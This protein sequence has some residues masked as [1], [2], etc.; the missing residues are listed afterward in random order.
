MARKTRQR[1]RHK[2]SQSLQCGYCEICHIDYPDLPTHLQSAIHQNYVSQKSNFIS[3]DKLINSEANVDSFL[4]QNSKRCLRSRDLGSLKNSYDESSNQSEITPI[5][6]TESNCEMTTK[7]IDHNK[8]CLR[9]FFKPHDSHA[10]P[11][12]NDS[13]DTNDLNMSPSYSEA[14]SD[15]TVEKLS[16]NKRCLRSQ[17][18]N[19]VKNSSEATFNQGESYYKSFRKN[20]D[21]STPEANSSRLRS[22]IN[23]TLDATIENT[24]NPSGLK[25][26]QEAKNLKIGSNSQDHCPRR[27]NM[28]QNISASPSYKIVG[29]KSKVKEQESRSDKKSTGLV[30]KFKRI[31]QSELL[32]L[33]DEAENFMFPKRDDTS[34]SESED[35]EKING[36]DK[37]GRMDNGGMDMVCDNSDSDTNEDNIKLSEIRNKQRFPLNPTQPDNSVGDRVGLINDLSAEDLNEFK[38]AFEC[39][40][41]D[42]WCHTYRRKDLNKEIKFESYRIGIGSKKFKLPYEMGTLPPLKPNCCKL[43]IWPDAPSVPEK[44]IRKRK[45]HLAALSGKSRKSPREHASTLASMVQLRKKEELDALAMIKEESCSTETSDNSESF[46]Q[47]D[48]LLSAFNDQKLF[49]DIEDIL[50]GGLSFNARYEPSM[51]NLIESLGESAVLKGL[52][53]PVLLDTCD[54]ENPSSVSNVCGDKREN[55]LDAEDINK[56]TFSF[57]CTPNELWYHTYKR[58]DENK[59]LKFLNSK[60]KN[61]GRRYKLPYELGPLPPLKPNCCKLN[62]SNGNGSVVKRKMKRKKRLL[63]TNRKCRKSPREHAILA[64]FVKIRKNQEMNIEDSKAEDE[65]TTDVTESN[66]SNVCVN[67]VQHLDVMLSDLCNDK[68]CFDVKDILEEGISFNVRYEPTVNNLLETL[69][70]STVLE[71][72]KFQSQIIKHDRRKKRKNNKTGWPKK[73]KF[74]PRTT[75]N[76]I[77]KDT[78]VN[79]ATQT[80]TCEITNDEIVLSIPVTDNSVNIVE[81]SS[82]PLVVCGDHSCSSGKEN[83]L[84]EN[85]DIFVECMMK[86]N[87]S[88]NSDN[89]PNKT[90]RLLENTSIDEQQNSSHSDPNKMVTLGKC[91]VNKIVSNNICTVDDASVVS[92]D[93]RFQP[94]VCVHKMDEP[95]NST[96]NVQSDGKKKKISKSQVSPICTLSPRKLRAPRGKWYRER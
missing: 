83:I 55:D 76:K 84:C 36:H 61:G 57:E 37:N 78:F 12:Y 88:I 89:E 15:D 72:L 41:N 10:K 42:L 7:C 46:Q 1:T 79:A 34:D 58:K 93:K 29:S 3:L 27:S 13:F 94:Y 6:S 11:S 9:S 14:I 32:V 67:S 18:V 74:L 50:E 62:T 56:L 16:I 5:Q 2:E 96:K 91:D 86:T 24:S 71:N 44:K 64:S 26:N 4:K 38:F 66:A 80:N 31:R 43:N 48:T 92:D 28:K 73:K 40:N 95:H 47:L 45:K 39:L 17:D 59:E 35:D 69:E 51:D 22:R 70:E 33:S 77:P 53:T 82:E 63:L 81:L 25:A 75:T 8:R 23:S 49:A 21:R 85:S 87:S 90:E 20:G 52:P 68:T 65:I 30:V 19:N 54:S 60:P